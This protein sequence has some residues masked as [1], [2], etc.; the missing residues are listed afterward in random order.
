MIKYL[1]EFVL[2]EQKEIIDYLETIEFTGYYK[3]NISSIDQKCTFDILHV[4]AKC[5]LNFITTKNLKFFSINDFLKDDYTHNLYKEKTSNNGKAVIKEGTK[6]EYDKVIGNTLEM[7]SYSEVL[8]KK[9]EGN[10]RIFI[11]KKIEIIEKLAKSDMACVA[12]ICHFIWKLIKNDENIIEILNQLVLDPYNNNLKK[13]FKNL[14]IKWLKD[15]SNR[16][17]DSSQISQK[18]NN[19]LFYLFKLKKYNSKKEYK[20]IEQGLKD[21]SYFR[22]HKRDKNKKN[23]LTRKEWKKEENNNQ[24][25]KKISD[26]ILNEN[27]K[28]ILISNLK[29]FKIMKKESIENFHFSELSQQKIEHG[30]HIHHIWP[31]SFWN[32]DI[33]MINDIHRHMCENLIL[34]NQIEH[35][36]IAHPKNKTNEIN[37]KELS[38][39]L[40]SQYSKI[41]TLIENNDFTYDIKKFYKLCCL[42]NKTIPLNLNNISNE[43]LFRYIEDI[44]I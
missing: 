37:E 23:G 43:M 15:N 2:P 1:K 16:N 19:P 17:K 32:P 18:I 40:L 7:L 44:I 8:D 21:L 3:K 12:F 31:R 33:E 24:F 6:K 34:L 26:T 29:Y 27:K 41:R 42:I 35:L 11:V 14:T 9:Y 38:S 36:G 22:I 13:Q 25:N 39:I 20:S 4:N 28:R 30:F 5:I 10:K